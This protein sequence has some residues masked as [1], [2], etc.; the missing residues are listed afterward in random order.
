[1]S[2]RE[3]AMKKELDELRLQ[4]NK[5]KTM[6]DSDS[7]VVSYSSELEE[8][9]LLLQEAEAQI[10]KLKEQNITANNELT[11]ANAELSRLKSQIERGDAAKED[12]VN[13]LK[14]EIQALKEQNASLADEWSILVNAHYNVGIILA[15]NDEQARTILDA[16]LIAK[17]PLLLQSF[18]VW[19]WF[20][21][22]I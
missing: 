18:K 21:V 10:S 19:L 9:D 1:M 5:R 7:N 14:T 16:G 15:G 20:Y 6:D 4:L 13:K 17:M 8:K 11:A 12:E 2:A 3:A 22:V